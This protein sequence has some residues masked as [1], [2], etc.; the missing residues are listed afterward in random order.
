M[1][2]TADSSQ[3]SAGRRSAGRTALAVAFVAACAGTASP[4]DAPAAYDAAAAQARQSLLA[5]HPAEAARIEKDV[6]QVR[7]SWREGD[8]DAAAMRAF[9][10]AEFIPRG[11]A[12]DAAFDRFEFA[13]ERGL[14]AR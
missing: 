5:R 6:E 1:K 4:A 10:E 3:P 8:G 2:P 9:L 11:P 13:L 12:L 7:R 14:G